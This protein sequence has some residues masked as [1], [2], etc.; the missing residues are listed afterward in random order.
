MT[1]VTV[2]DR[3]LISVV[4]EEVFPSVIEVTSGASESPANIL[5]KL[6]QV[7]GSGSGLDADLLDGQS[8]AWYTDIAARLGY[9]PVNKAGDTMLGALVLTAGT[10]LLPALAATGDLNTGVWF[11]AADTVA[12]STAGAE[13]FRIGS[14]GTVT[15]DGNLIVN[16]TTTTVNSTT[17]TIDDPIFTLGG[18]TAPVADDNKDRGIEFRYHDGATAKLGFFGYD[19]SLGAFTFIPDATNTSEVF[20]GTPGNIVVGGITS[21]S[22]TLTGATANAVPYFNG[23]AVLTTGSALTFDGT[24]LGIGVTPSAW[25]TYK[26]LQLANAALAC[27]TGTQAILVQ[28]AYYNGTDWKYETTGVDSSRMSIQSGNF[29]FETASAGTAG[30]V[31]TF[32]TQA[33]ILHTANA[34]NHVVLTGGTTGNT[35]SVSAAGSDA[36]VPLTLSA[37]GASNVDLYASSALQVRVLPTASA[38]RYLT[39]TGSNGG[40]PTIGTSAGSLA[41]SSSVALASSLFTTASGSILGATVTANTST[42]LS[43]SINTAVT[44]NR[45]IAGADASSTGTVFSGSLTNHPYHLRVNNLAQVVVNYTASA[46]NYLTLTGSATGNSCELSTAGS[47][48]SVGL[49]IMPKANGAVLVYSQDFLV[50]ANSANGKISVGVNNTATFS[51]QSRSDLTGVLLYAASTN[52]YLD[53]RSNGTGRISLGGDTEQVRVTPTAGAT[54]YITLTGSNGGNPTIGV[55]A[56]V[57]ALAGNV[58]GN[59]AWA[60]TGTFSAGAG[61]SASVIWSTNQSASSAVQFCVKHGA[62]GGVT[63]ENSRNGVA[64]LALNYDG[65]TTISNVGGTVA[66]F[67]YTASAVNYLSLTGAVTTAGPILAATGT[68]TNISLNLTP[69]GTGVVIVNSDTVRITTA[70]TPASAAATGTTGDVCWDSSYVYVCVATDTWKRAAIATW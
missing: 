63:I 22:F 18:D 48:A 9:T 33:R 43:I 61:D 51:I 37:K 67:S 65:S 28:N 13:R 39:L 26:V 41:I 57:L 56:G 50:G 6:L 64:T 19:D 47:D 59:S 5:A 1:P 40:N 34:V 17:V 25:G 31:V 11:P 46:V 35:A 60:T 7:D 30:G 27:Y 16:G 4:E 21:T 12:I 14:D 24:N 55:S 20:S 29:N 23:S 70:K 36:A 62:S 49:R 10:A 8:S 53:I 69:K 3:D 38:T 2:V 42:F 52:Y 44:E 68:D 45:F 54:R 32:S 15:V 58:S 66:L